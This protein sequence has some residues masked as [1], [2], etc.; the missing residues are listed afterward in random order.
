MSINGL[1]SSR[2]GFKSAQYTYQSVQ[3][4]ASPQADTEFRKTIPGMVKSISESNAKPSVK[5]D[6]K[7]K[8]HIRLHQ[9]TVTLSP[10]AVAAFRADT[11]LSLSPELLD[12]LRAM[13]HTEE[14]AGATQVNFAQFK[15]KQIDVLRREAWL[16][17]QSKQMQAQSQFQ[18][19]L[20]NKQLSSLKMQIAI[21]IA[22][23]VNNSGES[24]G[25]FVALE[26]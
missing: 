12:D 4:F 14:N 1:M 21:L 15:D 20:I 17:E 23:E 16:L 26:G 24:L 13:A 8:T 25:D 2:I 11:N 10:A 22:D 3:A 6:T 7:L 18:L 5:A 9:D 19:E